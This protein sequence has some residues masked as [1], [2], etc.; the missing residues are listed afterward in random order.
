MVSKLV[1]TIGIDSVSNIQD[2]TITEMYNLLLTQK[3]IINNFY[4][5]KKWDKYKKQSNLYEL[6]FSTGHNLPS[7][8]SYTPISRSFFKHWE[9]LHDF[10]NEL[11]FINSNSPLKIA[12]LAEGPGGFIESFVNFRKGQGDKI[13]GISL[14][15][16]NKSVP[17]WKFTK[18]YLLLNN[19]ELL[20]G[21]DKTGSLYSKENIDSYIDQI[22]EHTCDY[23]TADGGFDFSNNYNNQEEISQRLIASEIYTGLRIQKKHGAF[24]IKIYDINLQLTKQLIYI[25]KLNYETLYIIK[26]LT[27]RPANSEKYILCINNNGK[28]VH[29]TELEE[30]LFTSTD[31]SV[32]L[33]LINLNI[34]IPDCFLNDFNLLFVMKQITSINYNLLS[35]DCN[36]NHM[37]T[38]KLQIKKAIKW[39]Y[40]YNIPLLKNSVLFYKQYYHK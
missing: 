8:S 5:N 3:N 28:Y 16:T 4:C 27:S 12:C 13:Y 21:Y 30:L 19:I 31:S 2:E 1:Y 10:K 11:N 35:I 18:E 24:L 26:P 25:L 29:L 14:V 33:G 6:I 23:I 22:G 32:L 34:D 9:I 20:Y 40:K 36:I 17:N 39:L 7:L 38:M 37:T 15:S